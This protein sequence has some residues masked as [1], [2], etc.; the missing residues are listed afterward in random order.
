MGSGGRACSVRDGTA[1]CYGSYTTTIVEFRQ[2]NPEYWLGVFSFCSFIAL[3]VDR[4]GEKK[5]RQKNTKVDA[6]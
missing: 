3:L 6:V 5:I 4:D 1:N 2:R